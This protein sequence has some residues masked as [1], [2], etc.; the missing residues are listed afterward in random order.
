VVVI[1]LM[2]TLV[3]QVMLFAVFALYALSGLVEPPLRLLTRKI[4]RTPLAESGEHR[5]R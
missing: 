2:F 1:L 3:P 5:A 4:R